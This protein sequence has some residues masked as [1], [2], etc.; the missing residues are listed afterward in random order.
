MIA[1]NIRFL[2]KDEARK[3]ASPHRAVGAFAQIRGIAGLFQLQGAFPQ[4]GTGLWPFGLSPC[5]SQSL[6]D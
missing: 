6:R 3:R 4:A 5:G 2:S 1:K